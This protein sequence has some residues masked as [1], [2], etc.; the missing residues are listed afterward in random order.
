[1]YKDTTEVMYSTLIIKCKNKERVAYTGGV[2]FLYISENCS[3]QKCTHIHTHT[4]IDKRRPVFVQHS[5]VRVSSIHATSNILWIEEKNERKKMCKN[6]IVVVVCSSYFYIYIPP[7]LHDT[8]FFA[9]ILFLRTRT[10]CWTF[11]G[12]S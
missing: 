12:P 11:I 1:M 7:F 3:L 10:H 9:S 8:N 5:F 6:W 4:N 2:F